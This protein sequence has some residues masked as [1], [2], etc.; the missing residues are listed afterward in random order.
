ML[1]QSLKGI[2][3][4]MLSDVNTPRALTVHLLIEN[5]E[6][7]QLVNLKVDPA[8]YDNPDH[9]WLDYQVTELLRKCADLPTGIDT[10]AVA[11]EG[12]HAA[13]R[14]CAQ[15]NFRLQPILEN[16][17]MGALEYRAWDFSRDAKRLVTEI[18]GHLPMTL[19]RSRFGPGATFTDK[20]R[21]TTVPHKM[22]SQPSVTSDAKVFESFWTE[23][24]WFRALAQ[25]FPDRSA[26][27]VVR[28][29]RFTTVPKDA[30]K[31]RGIAI[32]PSLNVFFQLG[33]GSLLRSRLSKFGIDL[34]EGQSTHRRMACEASQ[35][36][37][38]AT[39]DLSSASDTVCTNLVKLLLPSHWYEVL[40]SLRSPTTDVDGRTHHLQKFSSMGNGFTFELETLLFT[41]ICHQAIVA[42]GATP[43]VGVNFSVY[44]DDIIVP[45]ESAAE[46]LAYL[47]FFGFKANQRKTFVDGP[48][49]ESCGGDF[50][51]GIAVRPFYL[52]EIPSTA[53]DWISFA[54]GIRRSASQ[55]LP[56]FFDPRFKKTWFKI[57][58]QIPTAIR[59]LRGPVSLGDIVIH[60]HRSTWKMK[61]SKGITKIMVYSS[62]ASKISLRKFRPLTQL[63]AALYGI[64]SDGIAPRGALR[65]YRIRVTTVLWQ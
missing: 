30:T 33:V 6:F 17:P 28:G 55:Q 53:E 47:G 40:N 32:E 13:E 37:Q 49:R 3:R 51:K 52:K 18:L 19:D 9:F 58:D 44:G 29:N 59:K 54:N 61:T 41:A 11:L 34:D 2:I 65:R 48:F 15:T 21:L 36:G 62:Q 12:F 4:Q 16:L 7:G 10:K 64:P 14:Q 50:F 38:L 5:E 26:P 27:L 60:D 46:V 56:E 20:G 31:D 8:H 57:L 39:I 25:E 63:A 42:T 45:T 1:P 22:Q 23:T 35:T 24:S 43:I